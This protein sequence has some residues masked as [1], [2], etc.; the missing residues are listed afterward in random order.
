MLVIYYSSVIWLYYLNLFLR[1][2][3]AVVVVVLFLILLLLCCHCCYSC[4]CCYLWKSI[5]VL[6][7]CCYCCYTCDCCYIVTWKTVAVVARLLLLPG[8][9][10][11]YCKNVVVVVVF[12]AIILLAR[13]S[14]T[15]RFLILEKKNYYEKIISISRCKW[16]INDIA[17]IG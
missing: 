12:L 11:R 9:L 6:Q 14:V 15:L 17:D 1:Q 4:S 10:F 7:K 8:S 13:G 16:F 2:W 3:F 5:S